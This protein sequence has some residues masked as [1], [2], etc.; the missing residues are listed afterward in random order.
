MPRSRLVE[1]RAIVDLGALAPGQ[2][3]D[4]AGVARTA[5][6]LNLGTVQSIT[7]V[8]VPERA[9]VV[10]Y[11]VTGWSEEEVASLAMNAAVQAEPY[12]GGGVD[13]GDSRYPGTTVRTDVVD[14]DEAR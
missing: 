3:G 11:D 13:G 2:T 14:R 1:V 10:T 4:V 6:D 8:P 9:L 12:D 5:L 7:A